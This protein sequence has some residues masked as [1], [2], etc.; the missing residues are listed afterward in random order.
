MVYKNIFYLKFPSSLRHVH[1]TPFTHSCRLFSKF[2]IL[3]TYQ[4]CSMH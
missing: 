4:Y 3:Q 1:G 2:V